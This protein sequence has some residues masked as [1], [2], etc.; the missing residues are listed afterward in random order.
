MAG[1]EGKSKIRWDDSHVNHL[2]ADSCAVIGSMAEI[3]LLFG[4]EKIGDPSSVRLSDRVILS[5]FTAKQLS[6]ALNEVMQEYEK[7]FGSFV[8]MEK[9]TPEERKR[10][11]SN[12][13]QLVKELDVTIGYEQSVKMQKKS[14]ADNRFLLGISKKEIGYKA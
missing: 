7:K 13:F 3:Y 2:S 9:S 4:T 5:P 6:L 1:K 11:G 8:K 10:K 14:M 12:L